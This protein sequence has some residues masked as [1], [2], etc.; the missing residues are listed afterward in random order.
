MLVCADCGDGVALS[1][2][3]PDGVWERG[4]LKVG[5][6]EGISFNGRAKKIS[7]PG[8]PGGPGELG[9]VIFGIRRLDLKPS[10]RKRGIGL[11]WRV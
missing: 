5:S 10:E 7:G 6:F 2:A 1:R 11:S 9:S 4:I 3:F 8:G